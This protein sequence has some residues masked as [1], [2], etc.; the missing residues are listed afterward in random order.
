[1]EYK[2]ELS[3]DLYFKKFFDANR[4]LYGYEREEIF[5]Y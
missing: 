2:E 5:V 1:M 3:H 4:V